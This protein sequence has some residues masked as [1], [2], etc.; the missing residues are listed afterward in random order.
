MATESRQG[1]ELPPGYVVVPGGPLRSTYWFWC[2]IGDCSGPK[3]GRETAAI[4]AAWEHYRANGGS[5]GE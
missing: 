4:R 5:D 1:D 2:K 3:V